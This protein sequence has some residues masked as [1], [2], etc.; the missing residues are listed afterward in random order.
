[1]DKPEFTFETW[2]AVLKVKIL[3]LCAMFHL[4]ALADLLQEGTFFTD[5]GSCRRH[6]A[7]SGGLALH[8]FGVFVHLVRMAP[9]RRPE[10]LFKIAMCHDLAKVGTYAPSF[11]NEQRKGPD[12]KPIVVGFDRNGKEKYDWDRVPIFEHVPYSAPVLGHADSSII[13]ALR[14]DI[15][16]DDA[17]LM[18]IRWHMGRAD[19]GGEDA[20]RIDRAAELEP[21]VDLTAAADL[22]DSHRPIVPAELNNVIAD[23]FLKLGHMKAVHETLDGLDGPAIVSRMKDAVAAFVTGQP[24]PSLTTAA[25]INME[26]GGD[27]VDPVPVPGDATDLAFFGRGRSVKMAPEAIQAVDVEKDPDAALADV[28]AQARITAAEHHNRKLK[29]AAVDAMFPDAPAANVAGPLP[30][31]I[32]DPIARLIKAAAPVKPV[33]DPLALAAGGPAEEP[34]GE[35]QPVP[36]SP[37][38]IG[39]QLPAEAVEIPPATIKAAVKEQDE[40][41]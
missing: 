35:S 12:G 9:D 26:R 30:S 13:R 14:G 17:E 27:L 2:P 6:H 38:G 15:K 40:L 36:T 10:R 32:P 11:K 28:L 20:M 8:S 4:G 37:S 18:A 33:V 34:Q 29:Q 21:L 5:P 39:I 25:E 3:E 23:L 22:L 31:N 7:F 1:M 19:A 24:D 16:L 41:F